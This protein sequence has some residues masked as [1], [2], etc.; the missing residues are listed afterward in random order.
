[1]VAT[2]K[3]DG[4]LLNMI[5]LQ[6]GG[7]S[8]GSEYFILVLNALEVLESCQLGSALSSLPNLSRSELDRGKLRQFK[9][10]SKLSGDTRGRDTRKE[11]ERIDHRSS[12]HHF[13]VMLS[14]VFGI[15]EL[16]SL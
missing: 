9:G 5:P 3:I 14:F 2:R 4:T 15:G 6:R 16:S 10:L 7:D 8:G 1:M 12:W 13:F 11:L